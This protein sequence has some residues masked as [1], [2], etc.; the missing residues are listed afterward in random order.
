M[1]LFIAVDFNEL[2]DYFNELQGQL[3]G[4]AKLSLTKSFHLTLKFLGEVQPNK[5]DEIISI[6][7]GIKFEHFTAYLDSAGIFPDENNIRVVWVG[8]R[9]EDKIFELQKKIDDALK[10]LFKKEKGFKPHI[11]LA[12]VKYIDD[13][14]YFLEEIGK[15]KVE[16]KKIEVKNFKLMKSNLTA[17]RPVYEDLAVFNS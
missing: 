16:N 7:K 3:P 2:K 11:T 17:E 5:A 10:P 8:L 6:L 14:K 12:R 15:I 13:N 1:R 4:N 9:P